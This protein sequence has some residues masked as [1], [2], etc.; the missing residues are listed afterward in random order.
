MACRLLICVLVA[1]SLLLPH[2]VYAQ[3]QPYG[4]PPPVSPGYGPAPGAVPPGYG[5]L[6]G[7][8]FPPGTV[9]GFPPAPAPG[10]GFGEPPVPGVGYYGPDGIITKRVAEEDHWD[11]NGPIERMLISMARN[12]WVRVEYLHWTIDEPGFEFLGAPLNV[13]DPQQF[14]VFDP[15]NFPQQLGTARVPTLDEIGLNDNNGIRLVY[16]MPLT[17]GELEFSGFILEQAGDSYRAPELPSPGAPSATL[18]A[19][20]VLTNGGLLNQVFL[21]DTDYRVDY[22]SEFS[23]AHADVVFDGFGMPGE[24]LHLR[25]TL[26]LRYLNLR[27]R[28][29][30]VGVSSA[31]GTV[32][33]LVSTI[34]SEANNH[35]YGTML[36]ARLELVH[37]W[38]TVG[39]EPKFGL[40]LNSYRASVATDN[41]RQLADPYVETEEDGTIFSMVGQL[42]AYLRVNLSKNFSVFGGYD[43][44][45]LSDVTRPYDNIYY[46]DN[47]LNQLPGIV[48]DT[49]HRDMM[50]HGLMI[51]GEYHFR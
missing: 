43:W 6:G 22:T 15:A 19:T 1:S 23:G 30:Q 3:G 12:T 31:F 9:P 44:F 41:L 21:Y 13:Q 26:G 24:G 39:I 5:P 51:G 37:R 33:P 18:I 17:I 16:G 25:P 32:S 27:E 2:D 45:Y 10:Y 20:P 4:F 46:N 14:V 42:R 38:F 50:I 7:Q 34:D 8:P 28:M 29:T 49:K 40:N 48:V 35:L 47:G 11:E 36:G